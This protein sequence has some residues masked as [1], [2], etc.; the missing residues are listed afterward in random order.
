VSLSAEATAARWE[1]PAGAPSVVLVHGVGFGPASLTPVAAALQRH[2]EVLVHSRRGYGWRAGEAPAASVALHVDDLLEALDGLSVERA[3]LVG[4]SGGATV[5]MAA[6]LARPDRVA[7]A[8][9]HEPAVGSVAPELRLQILTALEGGADELMRFLAGEATWARL[10]IVVREWLAANTRLIES[11]AGAF[12]RYEPHFHDGEVEIPLICSLG[13]RSSD[14]RFLV[15][16]R[17]SARTGAPVLVVPGCGHLPQF[18]APRAFAELI[19]SRVLL[20]ETRR[21]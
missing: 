11:D 7:C 10:P 13:E 5:V 20:T 12:A 4:V 15:A 6:A 14:A 9:A 19:V 18:D 3:V 1:G 2:A 16:E 17:L 8:V 21:P